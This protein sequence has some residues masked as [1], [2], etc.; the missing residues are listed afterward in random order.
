M[1][2][3]LPADDVRLQPPGTPEAEFA[4][5]TRTFVVG[6]RLTPSAAPRPPARAAAQTPRSP[7]PRLDEAAGLAAAVDLD[8]VQAIPLNLP[9]IRPSTYLGKGRVGELA[10]LLTTAR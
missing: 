9:K 2:E 5:A 6:P 4:A 8:V 3:M 1:S 10:G 7:P